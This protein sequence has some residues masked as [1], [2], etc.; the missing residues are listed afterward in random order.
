MTE[1][2]AINEQ[3]RKKA[4]QYEVQTYELKDEVNNMK[5]SQMQNVNSKIM[6]SQ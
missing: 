4:S 3:L 2:K 1:L 6:R 5:R